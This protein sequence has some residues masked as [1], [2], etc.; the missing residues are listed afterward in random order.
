MIRKRQKQSVENR[1]ITCT[2]Q[3]VVGVNPASKFVIY[4][5]PTSS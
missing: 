4:D 3:R 1:D 2:L 5:K